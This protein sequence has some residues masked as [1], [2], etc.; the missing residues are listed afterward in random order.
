MTD[1]EA[2]DAGTAIPCPFVYANG[3]C[4]TGVVASARGYGPKRGHFFTVRENVRKYRL[5]CSDMGDHAGTA[6]GSWG[7]ERMEF[8]PDQIAPG[9]E[10]RLWA[11]GYIDQQP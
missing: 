4:C 2:E 9:V 6:H 1:V 11:E 5:W 3:R 8:Y 10:D 7:K